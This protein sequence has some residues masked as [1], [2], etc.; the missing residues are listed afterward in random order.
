VL[1]GAPTVAPTFSAFDQYGNQVYNQSNAAYLLL[2]AGFVPAP[3]VT[4]ISPTI[5]PAAGGTT[6]KISGTGFTAATGVRFAGTAAASFTIHS[7][8]SITAVSPAASAGTVDVSVTSE[9][10]PSAASAMDQFTFVGA[11]SVS[12]IDPNNGPLGGGTTVTITGTNF[13]YAPGVNFGE[14]HYRPPR[15]TSPDPCRLPSAERRPSRRPS[16]HGAR[17]R[18][19]RPPE[20]VPE[21]PSPVNPRAR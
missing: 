21:Q 14:T 4:G 5:G 13:T 11:P 16:E 15:R 7:D 19:E 8:T 10:G 9:G 3:R 18:P 6:L 20:P 12:G 2:A 1:S 17:S